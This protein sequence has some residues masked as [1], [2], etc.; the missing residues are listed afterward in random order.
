MNAPRGKGREGGGGGGRKWNGVGNWRVIVLGRMV[1][2]LTQTKKPPGCV[3]VGG[4]WWGEV[5]M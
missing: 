2:G 4:G 5:G 1:R 3:C